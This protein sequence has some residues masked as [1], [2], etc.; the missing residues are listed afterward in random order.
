MRWIP[1]P[2]SDDD[3]TVRWRASCPYALPF[4]VLVRIVRMA[5]A[6]DDPM[7]G[8][9]AKKDMVDED[10]DTTEIQSTTT[11]S[12]SPEPGELSTLALEWA[13]EAKPLEGIKEGEVDARRKGKPLPG[14]T[15]VPWR[16]AERQTDAVC[17]CVP[18]RVAVKVV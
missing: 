11:R 1:L 10:D 15:L 14:M 12:S 5:V 4:G 7:Q 16:R 8:I 9:L 18:G 13:E 2:R 6:A 3:E 17:W